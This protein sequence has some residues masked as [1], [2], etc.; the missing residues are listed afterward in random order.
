MAETPKFTS[1]T[2]VDRL[3]LLYRRW[4]RWQE[5]TL[6]KQ[7]NNVLQ[8]DARCTEPMTTANAW[9]MVRRNTLRD[10]NLLKDPRYHRSF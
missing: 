3:S 1:S 9:G 6:T 5:C 8:L 7:Q 10:M 2:Y 4:T